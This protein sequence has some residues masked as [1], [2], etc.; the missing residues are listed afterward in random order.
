MSDI[1]KKPIDPTL[2]IPPDRLI[3][4]RF[5]GGRVIYTTGND[6][7]QVT[8]NSLNKEEPVEVE[9]L[10]MEP[11]ELEIFMKDQKRWEKKLKRTDLK[12]LGAKRDFAKLD[13]K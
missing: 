11:A 6:H 8:V 5:S 13:L 2:T 10:N 7:I 4:N 3:L 9:E 1:I 12:K